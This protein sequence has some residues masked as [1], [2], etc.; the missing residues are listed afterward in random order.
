MDI[1]IFIFPGV[2]V[3]DFAA[4]YE[5]FSIADRLA[6]RD[7]NSSARFSISIIAESEAPVRAR[8]GLQI[9]PGHSIMNHPDL[10]V[11]IVPGGDVTQPLTS[12]P[13]TAWISRMKKKSEIVASVC[14]GA[15]LLGK[16]DLLQGRRVTTHW[17]DIGELREKVPGATVVE[18]VRW[19][20]EGEIVTS[21]GISAGLDMSLFL[22][23]RLSGRDLA[24]RTAKQMEY[25]WQP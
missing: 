22:L 7:G 12:P 17:E 20:D 10:D 5:V 13:V 15:F 18:G 3:L 4:P 19:V 11:L 25:N 16:A 21:A 6:R 24:L 1:G 2:E 23:Q 9:V 8:H 14:T